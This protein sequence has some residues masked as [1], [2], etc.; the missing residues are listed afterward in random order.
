MGL[1]TQEQI[2]QEIQLIPQE[3]LA[4]VY[5]ILHYFR[6]GLETTQNQPKSIMQYAGCWQDMPEDTFSELF[7]DI[8]VRRQQAFSRRV[9]RETGID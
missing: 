5:E 7:T 8:Q 2:L 4:V 1:L 9:S 6:L 3:Q